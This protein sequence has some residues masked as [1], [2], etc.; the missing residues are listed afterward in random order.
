MLSSVTGFHY[1][2]VLEDGTPADLGSFVVGRN[3]LP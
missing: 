2:L 1:V 3:N